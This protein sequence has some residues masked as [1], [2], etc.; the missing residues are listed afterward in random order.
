M[1]AYM[2]A[3]GLKEGT[4]LFY[5]DQVMEVIFISD[6]CLQFVIE[7]ID[8]KT[9]K[10]VKNIQKIAMNYF[11]GRFMFD[12]ITIIPFVDIFHGFELVN[13]FY[14]VKVM[15]IIKGMYLL[16]DSKFKHNIK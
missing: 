11:K 2:C 13:L 6:S 1:Y 4:V 9:R 8:V 14:A 7:Y 15:R 5:I 12:A 16:D 10:P 3:F